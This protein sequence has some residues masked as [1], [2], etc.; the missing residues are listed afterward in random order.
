MNDDFNFDDPDNQL[1]DD[2]VQLADGAASDLDEIDDF[3]YKSK[4]RS[5]TC[6]SDEDDEETMSYSSLSDHSQGGTI[7]CPMNRVGEFCKSQ[8]K[9]RKSEFPGTIA[10][11]DQPELVAQQLDKVCQELLYLTYTYN[12][13]STT[14]KSHFFF[15]IVHEGK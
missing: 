3:D 15:C 7:S 4:H 5:V 6:N 2:F 12:R 10:F 9:D 11:K 14:E 13:T 1:E 8:E